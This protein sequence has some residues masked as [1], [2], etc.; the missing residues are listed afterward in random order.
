MLIIDFIYGYY[1]IKAEKSQSLKIINLM[2]GFNIDYKNLKYNADDDVTFKISL[3]EY[4]KLLII[5]D[6]ND[7][8]VY[9]VYEKGLPYYIKRY[10][11]RIGIPVG[12][13][14]FF[15]ILWISTL[16]IWD[17]DVVGN[18]IAKEN[19]IIERLGELGCGIGSYIPSVDFEK[20][21]NSYIL[22]Y[23][24][25]SWITVNLTGT[26]AHVEIRERI[27]SEPDTDNQPANLI[28]KCDGYIESYQV[29]KG[30]SVIKVA[31]VVKKGDL[32][33]SGTVDMKDGT[34]KLVRAEGRVN[35]VTNKTYKVC[36]PFDYTRKTYTGVSDIKKNIKIFGKK[37]NFYINNETFI[38]KYDKIVDTNR[39]ILFGVIKLPV[40]V[41]TETYN[42]YSYTS[43]ELTENE[44]KILA[45]K[46]MTALLFKELKDV[47]LLE[48]NITSGIIDGEY[49]IT[50][51]IR[52]SE[53]ITELSIITIGELNNG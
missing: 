32:L 31:T 37:I 2:K 8:M 39:I 5:L 22:H 28:A 48:Q 15:V 3:I 44:A 30:Q 21:C 36:I 1:K 29:V 19:D 14:V 43:W 7:C 23:D 51:A 41:Q 25:A 17:I 45:E 42:E 12:L 18:N 26:V 33:I 16:F 11:K 47:D 50:S 35:A 53:D 13:I 27:I 40:T 49:V 46:E 34:I 20:L 4:K 9:I 6:K 10:R 52:C 38:E 24:D